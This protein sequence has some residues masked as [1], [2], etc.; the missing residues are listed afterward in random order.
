ML[1]KAERLAALKRLIRQDYATCE[2]V[3]STFSKQISA[4]AATGAAIVQK[5][6]AKK[7]S[8][9]NVLGVLK[10]L[11]SDFKDAQGVLEQVEQRVKVMQTPVM[12]KM[13][14][15]CVTVCEEL[16]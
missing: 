4:K 6:K 2:E 12:C 16:A 14:K 3:I 13:C 15:R 1:T 10:T 9:E 5:T 11:R 8:L 7:D